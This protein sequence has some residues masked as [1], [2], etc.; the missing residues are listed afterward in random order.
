MKLIYQ[1][2]YISI[3]KFNDIETPDFVVLT[4]INGSGKSHL[5]ESISNKSVIVEGSE[6]ARTVLFDYRNF[7]LENEAVYSARQIIDERNGAWGFLQGSMN[8]QLTSIKSNL[9]EGYGKIVEI[10]KTTGLGILE[11]KAEDI[12]DV[13]LYGQYKDYK[14]E[15]R[16]LFNQDGFKNNQQAQSIFSTQYRACCS[17]DEMTKENFDEIYAP[18][19][20]KNDFLPSQI[21][22]IVWDYYLK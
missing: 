21:G 22:R 20:L 4:G 7:Y 3:K 8:A 12:T 15:I 1:K 13:A 2:D 14:K 9:G 5:L 11:L 18:L 19:Q 10:C 16:E 6:K 17:L